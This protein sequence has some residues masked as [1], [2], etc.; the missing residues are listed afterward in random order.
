MQLVLVLEVLL[1]VIIQP[2]LLEAFECET[3]I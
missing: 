3:L 2:F 1:V